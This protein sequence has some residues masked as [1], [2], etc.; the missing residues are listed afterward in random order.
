[1]MALQLYVM[2]RHVPSVAQAEVA[3]VSGSLDLVLTL[4]KPRAVANAS[5]FSNARSHSGRR[6][7][8]S[9]ASSGFFLCC[10]FLNILQR[11]YV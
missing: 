7:I 9:R 4:K 10:L 6:M 8:Y 3:G 1:M 5:V 11:N 2:L